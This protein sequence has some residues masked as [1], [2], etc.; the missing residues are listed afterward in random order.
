MLANYLQTHIFIQVLPHDSIPRTHAHRYALPLPLHTPLHIPRS[1]LN[2][3]NVTVQCI[4]VSL[5][6]LWRRNGLYMF[7]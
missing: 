1:P 3:A 4:V 7:W 2:G 6:A 5:P